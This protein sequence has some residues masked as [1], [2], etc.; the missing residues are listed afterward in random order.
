MSTAAIV[1]PLLVAACSRRRR[2]ALARRLPPRH[3]TWLISVGAVVSALSRCAVLCLLGAVLVAQVAGLAGDRPLVARRPARKT[4][5]PS[6]GSAPSRWRRLLSA[7]GAAVVAGAGQARAMLAAGRAVDGVAAGGDLVV[8]EGPEPDAFAIPGRP[9]RIVVTR[10]L[11]RRLSPGERRVLLAHERAH[12]ARGHHWHRS[13]VSLAIAANPLLWPLRAAVAYATE[14]W[15]DEE[16]AAEV[17]DRRMAARAWRASRCSAA[18]PPTAHQQLA[19][20]GMAVPAR[21]SALLADPPRA[22]PLLS[23]AVLALPA[24]AL[25]A[26]LAVEMR[27]ESIFDVAVHVYRASGRG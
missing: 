5:R 24:L 1:S 14:R 17:G 23:L 20:G 13:A 27:V 2:T 19:A 8:I 16:A 25:A 22:R 7:P 11:L 10:S 3:A 9:G 18:V 21:V 26:A 12:L 6:P 4:R 15:A